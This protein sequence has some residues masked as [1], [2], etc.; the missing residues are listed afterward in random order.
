MITSHCWRAARPGRG[1]PLARH[2]CVCVCIS[3][4][5]SLY[6]YIYMSIHM[7]MY[8]CIYIYIYMYMCIYIHM[9]MCI[10]IYIIMCLCV[11]IYIYIYHIKS[12][13]TLCFFSGPRGARSAIHRSPALRSREVRSRVWTQ[14]RL[15][16][17][18]WR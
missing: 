6:M 14:F 13:I 17:G 7:Y 4:S 12:Y 3:L 2:M 1:E 8:I 9:Y 15:V 11:Y 5:L 16:D 18:P 10:Y